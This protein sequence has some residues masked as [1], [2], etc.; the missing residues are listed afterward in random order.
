MNLPTR[1]PEPALI[2]ST[3]MVI[4]AVAAYIL[5]KQVSTEWVE[6]ITQVYALFVAP[7]I[8]AWL[9]RRVVTPTP[10]YLGRHRKAG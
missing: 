4:T 9:T 8:A 5:G 1:A 7:M 10:E 3:G 2:R 6:T